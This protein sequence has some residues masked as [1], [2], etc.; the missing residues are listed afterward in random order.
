M[1]TGNQGGLTNEALEEIAHTPIANL[2][3]WAYNGISENE[4][5]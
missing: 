2:N 5:N 1:I 3:A 4:V